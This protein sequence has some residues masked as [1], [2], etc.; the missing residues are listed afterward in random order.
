MVEFDAHGRGDS[1][2][3]EERRPTPQPPENG[4][5]GRSYGASSRPASRAASVGLPGLLGSMQH[6]RLDALTHAFDVSKAMDDL[7]ALRRSASRAS[8]GQGR[9]ALNRLNCWKAACAGG[10][11]HLDGGPQ[12]S[13]TAQS[14]TRFC[15]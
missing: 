10:T 11:D 12:A 4:A 1:R 3:A 7:Q 5:E 13:C 2:P 9:L 6:G 15:L 14:D 8:V